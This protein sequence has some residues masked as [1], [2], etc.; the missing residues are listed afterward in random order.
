MDGITNAGSGSQKS[1]MTLINT[2]TLSNLS[3][4]TFTFN[5][6]L[7]ED[8]YMLLFILGPVGSAKMMGTTFFIKDKNVF[9]YGNEV[10][11]VASMCPI[12]ITDKTNGTFTS[13]ANWS[14]GNGYLQLYSVT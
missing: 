14:F 12:Q 6:S 10:P 8:M 7:T 4:N 9:C 1:K 11:N 13:T 5:V 3:G 2:L